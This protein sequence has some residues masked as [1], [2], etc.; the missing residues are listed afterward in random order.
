MES[1][2]GCLQICNTSEIDR[3]MDQVRDAAVRMQKWMATQNG[4]PL[5]LLRRMKFETGGF[6]PILGHPLNIVEQIN[7][8][9]TFVVALSAARHLLE[10]HPDAGGFVLAPGAHAA[11]DLDIMSK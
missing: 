11:I 4:D 1:P 5:V 9:W 2:A 8:A 3:Y 6:H 10:M 7:Q